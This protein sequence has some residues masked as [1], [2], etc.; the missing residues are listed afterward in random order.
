MTYSHLNIAQILN[1]DNIADFLEFL[2]Y[3]ILIYK[4]DKPDILGLIYSNKLASE[5]LQID[6]EKLIGKDF[7]DIWK[8]SE[9]ADLKEKFLSVFKTESIRELDDVNFLINGFT[10]IL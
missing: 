8:Y 1:S 10:G 9:V 5:I 7:S 6:C 4:F 2:P 3:G